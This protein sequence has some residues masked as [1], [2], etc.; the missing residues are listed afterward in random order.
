MWCPTTLWH[1]VAELLMVWAPPENREA[2]A[3]TAEAVRKA[4]D[5]MET[6][7]PMAHH[8]SAGQVGWLLLSVSWKR[9]ATMRNQ[10]WQVQ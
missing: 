3:P 7:L 5:L 9:E 4:L 1:L 10:V 6:S 2:V 8:E